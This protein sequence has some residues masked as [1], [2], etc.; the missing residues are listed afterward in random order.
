MCVSE[1]DCLFVCQREVVVLIILWCVDFFSNAEIQLKS[2]V[3]DFGSLK[4]L[5]NHSTSVT[6]TATI[7]LKSC[8]IISVLPPH[9]DEPPAC[10]GS[11]HGRN[12]LS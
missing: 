3:H 7:S 4:S 1:Y 5:Y 2:S 9:T 6:K 12:K 11:D 10:R 8:T